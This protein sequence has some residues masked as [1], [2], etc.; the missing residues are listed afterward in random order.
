MTTHH[1]AII[2]PSLQSPEAETSVALTLVS[3]NMCGRTA[4]NFNEDEL[5]AELARANVQINP[6]RNDPVWRR[7]YLPCPCLGSANSSH[8]V[9]PTYNQPVIRQVGERNN[10][11]AQDAQPPPE[12]PSQ[13]A[14]ESSADHSAA[15]T[16]Q[17]TSPSKA[18]PG[19]LIIQSMRYLFAEI[20]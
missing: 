7:T 19:D 16:L 15:S 5:R 3:V 10:Q 18:K 6:V 11:G 1:R 14:A 8:N 4:M 12:E 17:P 9:A 20:S 13:A 2:A